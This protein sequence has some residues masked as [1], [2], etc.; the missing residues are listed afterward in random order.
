MQRFAAQSLERHVEEVR[1]RN[2]D[3]G[4]VL[5]VNNSTGEVWAY[6]GSAGKAADAPWVDAVRAQRKRWIPYY[7]PRA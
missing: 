5:V 2:V 7:V 6:V 4:A 3:D 1:D